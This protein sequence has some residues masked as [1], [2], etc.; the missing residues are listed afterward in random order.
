MKIA[1]DAMGGDYAPQEIV[2]GVIQ[3]SRDTTAEL[4]LVGQEENIKTELANYNYN[5][6]QIN[7]EPASQI[8]TMDESPTRALRRKKDSSIVIGSDLVADNQ[9]DAFVSA[10]STG[11]VM[12]AATFNIG[13]IKGV[14]RP[15][16]GTVFP[17][18]KGQTLLL[19]AGANV[20]SKAENLAQQALM[21]HVY[22]KEVFSITKPRIGL[23]SIGEEKKKGNKLTKAAYELLAAED[24]ID[25][26]GNAE[27]RDI[28]TGEFDVIVCDGFVGNV[29]LKTVEGLAGTIFKLVKNEVQKNWLTKIGGLFLKP[30]LKSVKQKMDYT[31][32]GGAPLLGV[33]GVTIISHG[34]SNAKAIA[35]AV[36][37]AEEAATVNL[38]QLIKADIDEGTD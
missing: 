38:P 4:V 15:A 30:V 10:G 17:A 18:L 29:V 1:I 13:R 26:A 23:L 16:I 27:G 36:K 8:I 37:N 9:V 11:A 28:F 14:K 20:D 2:K 19:D 25:F 32:Y 7:V 34:S 3:A 33:D 12:A 22:M 5:P 31:E 21:G 24:K 35:N 6:E